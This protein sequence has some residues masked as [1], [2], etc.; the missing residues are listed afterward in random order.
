MKVN[1][2]VRRWNSNVVGFYERVGYSI[3]DN[4]SMGKRLK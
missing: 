3:E 1:L 2:Q 4:V